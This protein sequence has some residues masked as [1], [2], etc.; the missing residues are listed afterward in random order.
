LIARQG[1]DDASEGSG[2]DIVFYNS[3]DLSLIQRIE[4]TNASLSILD[5]TFMHEKN[6]LMV[7]TGV[8]EVKIYTEAETDSHH[9]V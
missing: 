3:H 8:P 7:T 4:K 9:P 6:M 5:F 2:G 1:P